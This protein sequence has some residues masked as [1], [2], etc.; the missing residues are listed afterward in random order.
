MKEL[1]LYKCELCGHTYHDKDECEKCESLHVMPIEIIDAKHEGDL[2][3]NYPSYILIKFD[4][5]EIRKYYFDRM[6]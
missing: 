1:T 4:N 5:G 2:F 6:F 3:D